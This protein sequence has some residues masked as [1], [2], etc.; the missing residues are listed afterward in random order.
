MTTLDHHSEFSSDMSYG[1]SH[2]MES[3]RPFPVMAVFHFCAVA[4]VAIL[5][6]VLV[7]H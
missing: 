1:L 7:H 6:Y 4:G 3:R 5:S 2:R